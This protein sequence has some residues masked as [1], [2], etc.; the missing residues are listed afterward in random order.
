MQE[1]KRVEALIERRNREIFNPAG[2][3]VL[4]PR[5]AAL[6][7]VCP[8]FATFV[9][10]LKYSYPIARARILLNKVFDLQRHLCLMTALDFYDHDLRIHPCTF[11]RYNTLTC[12]SISQYI[13]MYL[14]IPDI[15]LLAFHQSSPTTS[16]SPILCLGLT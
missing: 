9:V 2:L 8:P 3:N 14:I 11:H 15:S 1:L 16:S 6:Q 4:S 10:S 7:F 5:Y 13:R 12:F